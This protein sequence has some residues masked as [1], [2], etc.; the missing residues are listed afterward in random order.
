MGKWESIFRIWRSVKADLARVIKRYKRLLTVV[1]ASIFTVSIYA[2]E[3]PPITEEARL[4]TS[5]PNAGLNVG[6]WYSSVPSP[7]GGGD[8]NRF[9]FYVPCGWPGTEDIHVDLYSPELSSNGAL[10]EVRGPTAT[11]ADADDATFELYFDTDGDGT[12]ELMNSITYSPSTAPEDWIRFV[13][14]T[15]PVACG[16]YE[17]Q[18]T[19]SDDDDNSWRF[20][21]SSDDDGDP[22]TTPPADADNPDGVPGT[23]DELMVG[24]LQA[25]YQHVGGG[26]DCTT[27]YNVV[28]EG[29]PS[30]TFNNFD[31]DDIDQTNDA[32]RRVRY[33]SPSDTIDPLANTGGIIGTPSPQTAWNNGTSAARGGDTVNSPE[34]GVWG[35]VTC[36]NVNNQYIQ[37][38]IE[39]VP[40]FFDP[41]PIPDIEVTKDNGQLIYTAGETVT[42]DLTFTNAMTSIN[43]GAAFNVTLTDTLPA[44]TTL[45]SCVINSP[46]SGTCVESA[47]QLDIAISQILKAGESGTVTVTLLVDAGATGDLTNTVT[48]N[49]EDFLGNVQTDNDT[50]VDADGPSATSELDVTKVSDAVGPVNPGQVITYTVTID[51]PSATPQ[52]GIIVQDALPMGTTYVAQSTVATG[53]SG[54]AASDDFSSGGYAGGTGWVTNLVENGDDGSAATGLIS[55]VDNVALLADNELD[56]SGNG[57]ASVQREVDLSSATSATLAFDWVCE[58][59]ME[60]TDV[61]LVEVSADGLV[62][63]PLVEFRGDSTTGTSGAPVVNMCPESGNGTTA[64]TNSGSE[65]LTV[66]PAEFST[67]TVLRIS[68]TISAGDEDLYIDNVSLTALG[69]VTLDNIPGSVN[70]DLVDGVPSNLV[71]PAD[72]FN[73]APSETLT[74]TYQVQVDDPL[75]FGVTDITNVAQADSNETDPTSGSFTDP[76]NTASIS[77]TAFNDLTVDGL[78]TGESGLMGV[79]VNLLDSSGNPVL[80]GNGLPVTTTTDASGNYTFTGLP[81]GNYIVEF[82]PPAGFVFSPQDQGVDDTIDSDANLLTGVTAVISVNAGDTVNDID[83]GLN[84][85]TAIIGDFVWSDANADGI[86]DSGEP[87]IAGVV[88]ELIDPVTSEVISSTTTAAD[89]SYSFSG[90]AQGDYQVN[91]ADSNFNVG[92]ALDGFAV[93]SGPQS[94]TDPTSTFTVAAGDEF[95]TADF[96]FNNSSLFSITDTIWLDN[97]GDGLLDVGK[98]RISNV[99]VQ[100]LDSSNNVIATT[101]TGA[102]GEFTFAGLAPGDYTLVIEDATNELNGLT[103]TTAA[104]GA[105]QL[106]VTINPD[107]TITNDNGIP[108]DGIGENFGY[109]AVN[110]IGDIIYSDANGNGAQD[111]GEAGIGNVTVE[112]VTAGADGIF[113]NGDDVTVATA[114]TAVD[115]SYLF[116]GLPPGDYQV[117]VTDLNGELIGATQTGDPDE[118]GTCAM[119]DNRGSS[120]LVGGASDLSLDFGYQDPSLGSV[121]GSIFNDIDFDAALGTLEPGIAGIKVN[122]VDPGPDGLFGTPDDVVVATTMTDA[123]GDYSFT[124]VS[125]DPVAGT[126]YFVDVVDATIPAQFTEHTTNNDPSGL[127][128]PTPVTLDSGNPNPSGGAVLDFGYAETPGT[129]GDT[130]F[131]DTNGDGIQDAGELGEPNV[132]VNLLDAL[133]SPVLDGNGVAITTT[134]DATGNYSFADIPPGDYIVE[135]VAPGGFLFSPQDQ[136]ADDTLD[137]DANTSTGQTAVINLTAGETDNTVDAGVRENATVTETVF[138]DLNGNGVLDVGEELA[139]IDVVFTVNGTPSTVVTDANGVATFTGAAAGDTVNIDVQESDTD[140]PAGATLT[141]GTDPTDVTAIGGATVTDTTG[142]E[143]PMIPTAVNDESLNNPAGP[144]TLGVTGNDIDPDGSIDATTVNFDPA[145]VG[146]IGTDTDGDGDIDQVVVAGQGTWAVD[147]SGNVTFSPEAGFTGNPTPIDYTVDDNDGNT[148]NTA[149]ITITYLNAPVTVDDESL[150]NA[151]GSTVVVDVLSNDTD[152]DGLNPATVQIVGTANP[153]DPLVVPGEG[154]WT[155]NPLTGEITFTP[156]AGFTGDPTPI[157]YTVEDNVGNISSPATVTVTYLD[158]PVAVNDSSLDNPAGSTVLLTVTDNDTD[159]DGTINIATVD[160]DPATPGQQTTLPVAGEG[161]WSVDATGVVTFVP[162]AGFTGNPTPITYTVQDNDGN[163]SNEATITITYLG[164]TGSIGDLVFDDLNGNG[165]LDG[166]ELGLEGVIVNLVDAT[167]SIVDTTATAA[168]GSYQFT[169]VAYGDYTLQ[170]VPLAGYLISPADQGGNDAM[171]SDATPTTGVTATVT[172]DATTDPVLNVD[173]GMFQPASI[174]DT[175]WLDVDGD[176][177]QDIGE[178]GIAGVTVELTGFDGNGNPVTLTTITD[179][180]GHYVFDGLLAGAYTLTVTDLG[181]DGVVGT[182]DELL[183]GLTLAPGSFDNQLVNVLAGETN[184]TIDIGYVPTPGTAT[185]GDLI[186]SDADGDGIQDAGEAGIGGVV[187]NVL[188]SSGNIALDSFGNFLTTTTNADGT[189][190]F[191]NVLPGDYTVEIDAANF[192]PGGALE[193]L[194]AADITDGPQSPGSDTSAPITVVADDAYTQADFGINDPTTFTLTDTVW[195]DAN[196]DGVQDVDEGGIAGVTVDLLDASGN[197]IASTTT[198]ANGDF[199]FTGLEDGVDYTVL[200][201]DQGGVLTGQLAT[202]PE[203]AAGEYTV[204]ANLAADAADG[205]IDGVVSDTSFGYNQPGVI[206]GTIYSDAD[207]SFAQGGGEVGLGGIT[208]QLFDSTNTLIDTVTTNPDGSYQFTG[209]VPDD[210]TITVV[211]ALGT[212][213]EDPDGNATPDTATVTL[214]AG[215]SIT[216][217]DFG[218]QNTVLFDVAGTIFEDTDSDGVQDAGEVGIAG[219]TVDLIDNSG[220]VVATTTTDTNGNYAFPDITDGVSNNVFTIAVTDTAGVLNG[221]TLTSGLDQQTVT[222]TSDVNDIDFGYVAEPA[223]ASIVSTVWLDADGDGVQDPGEEGLSGVTLDLIDLGPDGI[224]GTADDVIVATTTTD[225]NGDYIFDDLPPGTHAVDIDETTLPASVDPTTFDGTGMN[226]L[227]ISDSILLSEGETNTDPAFGFEPMSGTAVLSGVVW[228]DADSDG[229]QGMGEAGIGGVDVLIIDG[230]SGAVVTVPTNP[231]GSWVATGLSAGDY[232]VRYDSADIPGGLN[233]TEPSNLG[234]QDGDGQ[235]DDQYLVTLVVDQTVSDLDFGFA[236]TDP[237]N[238]PTGGISGTFYS[239]ADGVGGQGVGEPGIPGVTLNLVDSVGNIVA[240]TTTDANGDY[241][242]AGVIPG[243]YTLQISDFNGTLNGLNPTEVPSSPISVSTGVVTPDVDFGYTAAAGAGLIG[244][245]VWF[246]LN[247]D[248]ALDAGEPGVAGVS[249]DVWLDTNNNGVIEPGVDNRVRTVVTDANGNYEANGL[250]PGDYLVN[251]T[252][253]AGVLSGLMQTADPDEPG[254]LCVTCDGQSDV[255][256]VGSDRNQDFGY[257]VDPAAALSISGVIYEDIN[258][259]G[260]QDPD[261]V[262]NVLGNADDEVPVAGVPVTLFRILADGSKQQLQS[263][264]TAADGSYQFDGLPDGDTYEVVVDP[265]GTIIDGFAQTADPDEPGTSCVVCDSASTL[266]LAG[267]DISGVDFGYQQT[268][269]TNPITLASFEAVSGVNPGDVHIE[270]STS[271]ETGNVGFDL[272]ARGRDTDWVKLNPNVIPSKVINSVAIQHYALDV[273]GVRGDV[274]AIADIDIEGKET[275]H[276]PFRLGKRYGAKRAKRQQTDWDAIRAEHGNKK[277]KRK[278]RKQRKMNERQQRM[279][280][281][282]DAEERSMR[283]QMKRKQRGQGL[284]VLD[285]PTHSSAATTWWQRGLIAA[286]SWMIPS[287]YA[288]DVANL[289]VDQSGIHR[290]SYEQLVAAGVDIAGVR[291]NR[292]ALSSQGGDVARRVLGPK[293]VGP[294]TIIEFIGKEYETLYTQSNVYTLGVSNSRVTQVPTNKASVPKGVA[295]STYI[296]TVRVERDNHYSASSPNGDPWYDQYVFAWG[297]TP[298]QIDV[299]IDID[300][301]VPSAGPAALD[302]GVWGWTSTPES[303][304]HHVVVDLNGIAVADELFDGLVAH[305]IIAPLSAG[306]QEGTN[307]ITVRLPAD[308]GAFADL[309]TLDYYAL[310][311]PRQLVAKSGALMF[312]GNASVYEVSGLPNK[313]VVVYRESPTGTVERIQRIQNQGSNYTAR[314]GGVVEPAG[315][316]TFYVAAVNNI[317]SPQIDIPVEPMGITSAAAEYL[318][319][320]HPDF[321]GPE[322]DLLVD[323]RQAQGFSVEVVDVEQVYAEFGDYLPGAEPIKDYIAYAHANKGTTHVLLVG[324]D[325]Y[326]YHD[327]LGL[328][329]ISFMPTLYAQTD[330][331]IYFAPVDTKFADVDDDN[332]PDVAIG[333]FPVRTAGELTTMVNQ[334][335]TYGQ[336][337]YPQTAVFAAD[338]FDVANQYSFKT[339]SDSVINQHLSNWDVTTAYIDDLGVQGAKD[340]IVNAINDGVALT[341]FFGHSDYSIWTFDGLLDGADVDALTNVGLPTVVTQWGCWNTYYVSPYED[342]LGHRF[343]L[344]GD[345]GAASVLGASTLTEAVAERVLAMA[346]FERLLTPG[347]TMGDA[348]LQAKQDYAKTNPDQLDV[349]LGWTQLGDPALIVQP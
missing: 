54:F 21:V 44:S 303:P 185:I 181:P 102:N 148:S 93:T 230:V 81:P 191:T 168:D 67:N 157:S 80:D 212:Q 229:T 334:T 184:D 75:V 27:I 87:G 71:L 8:V 216:G 49:G 108:G 228:T 277:A 2:A 319:I 167:G 171:D 42:Y 92:N 263:V 119:C 188:D 323:A 299:A 343:M 126:D 271:M 243:N 96:G 338:K 117:V 12:K 342:T 86:Q 237:V 291:K 292:L 151:I 55:V 340:T 204:T 311:Y 316:S 310:N 61:V 206:E 139:N 341:S 332:V 253:T 62:F 266:T 219:V 23:G 9:L 124:G 136:G 169:N 186:W 313:N 234:D 121:S 268:L 187:I 170:F 34:P 83:A 125:F 69:S 48:A 288:M 99:T 144:V 307:T 43:P 258:G 29:E 107:G 16:E 330:D 97:D 40:D 346:V 39:G 113:G 223:T 200:V 90:V 239:D 103:G 312:K 78:Q 158:P 98:S 131:N 179:A 178:T 25:T 106:A 82:E 60:L 57:T 347:T 50:D 348:I 118:A 275:V 331:I 245:T 5:G 150:D 262:D 137:S 231:D 105:G 227:G 17:M 104:A 282:M 37:E 314:F 294:G 24:T 46:F 74:V 304:D 164:N 68:S 210:Y 327:N 192:N 183:T 63:S 56:F 293:F 72:G 6:D 147:A 270:W 110:S 246:D 278:A 324:G 155:I 345:R 251:V 135:F 257:G 272:Y 254:I 276:G 26:D 190:L 336:I 306:L 260:I 156:E 281:H 195:N 153:G 221:S 10:D 161:T 133:G 116:A 7:P 175:I 15:A 339:D 264:I 337:T 247:G 298:S 249:L 174:G 325:S 285:T 134:T 232:I 344:N 261:G 222:V 51:N 149:T 273:S 220:N 226:P 59:D 141:V 196:G 47:G 120:T 14:L 36:A 4:Q 302:V 189:Y 215:E 335:L 176:G 182:G 95:L 28:P 13:S 328:G 112:L 205:N 209:L 322:L 225:A 159:T 315:E 19:T 162:N 115:G 233:A 163:T 213:T 317:L 77:G 349:I 193:G 287:A 52:T 38:G 128:S 146:G 289:Q 172:L 297:T 85:T 94:N 154:T 76:V 33:Y 32:I 100:L 333:R 202:T 265:S 252:D 101:T 236:P 89:G 241:S 45:Q 207:S 217:A 130:V 259:D 296:E 145:S 180:D 84:N 201:S 79:V 198:D 248:G 326:D 300:H 66:P 20:R 318:I 280:Q 173:T 123:N 235:I 305:P 286:V 224:F 122:L 41:P 160:L 30:V 308:T 111:A 177:V 214:G 64:D 242:F 31:L 91:I 301:Y 35:I 140:F 284:S 279:E 274:F 267:S 132:V 73:L 250:P 53:P 166:G 255:V 283:R 199:T 295:Q 114:T 238:P 165:I 290:V 208:V 194:T 320:T 152:A 22:T 321:I 269:V 211:G 18:V 11:F 244:D 1:L 309:V 129:I 142:Y 88:V 58:G 329:A 240:T 256:L 109:A 218:Y 197:V 65:S 138:N 203:S 143:Q 3:I 127:G 70:P